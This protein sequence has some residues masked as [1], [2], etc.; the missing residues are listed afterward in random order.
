MAVPGEL[1]PQA[2]TYP[3]SMSTGDRS[4]HPIGQPTSNPGT[5]THKSGAAAASPFAIGAGLTG[6]ASTGGTT[7]K[8]GNR[9]FGVRSS[10]EVPRAT[11]VGQPTSTEVVAD[12]RPEG[13]MS[14]GG[15]GPAQKSSDMYDSEGSQR[16]G[17]FGN[18]TGTMTRTGTSALKHH[19][20]SGTITSGAFSAKYCC[21]NCG[22]VF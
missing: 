6:T 12:G 8:R 21:P 2:G 18:G 10:K 17:L 7:K 5:T 4:T 20:H 3:A 11:P 15:V 14:T 1:H 16:Q 9:L 19:L 22:D 13:A